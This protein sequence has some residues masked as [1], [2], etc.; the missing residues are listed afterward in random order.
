M[1]HLLTALCFISAL[2]FSTA[3]VSANQPYDFGI[4][5]VELSDSNTIDNFET[6]L[7]ELYFEK[8]KKK[9]KALVSYVIE[10]SVLTAGIGIYVSTATP[11]TWIDLQPLI[12]A[13][14]AGLVG[15]MLITLKLVGTLIRIEKNFNRNVMKLYYPVT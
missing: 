9:N 13:W 12:N 8:R 4:S 14:V 11:A 10:L 1:N 5:L 6:E 15:S 3:N 2:S 7:M